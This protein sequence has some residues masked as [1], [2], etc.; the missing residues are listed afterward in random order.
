MTEQEIDRL[1]Q[2]QR[3]YF[4]SGATLPLAARAE[5][6]DRLYAVLAAH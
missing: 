4:L 1:L 2:R 5:A 3:D 6:L